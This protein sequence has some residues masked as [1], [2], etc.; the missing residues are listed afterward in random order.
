MTPT[1][2]EPLPAL[3]SLRFFAALWVM[4]FHMSDTDSHVAQLSAAPALWNLVSVGYRGVNLFFILS[5]FILVYNYVDTDF[6]DKQSRR[7]FW[8]ARFARIYPMY[9][10][11][12]LLAVPYVLRDMLLGSTSPLLLGTSLI[13]NLALLQSW[14]PPFALT[15]NGPGWSLSNE[16]WFYLIFPF[17]I[18]LLNPCSNRRFVGIILAATGYC[19][20][21]VGLAVVLDVPGFSGATELK[22]SDSNPLVNFFLFSPLRRVPEFVAG[23]ALGFLYLRS[24]RL[25]PNA[26]DGVTLVSGTCVLAVCCFG[27]EYLP[28]P[29]FH[30]GLL[31]PAWCGLIFGLAHSESRVAGLLSWQTLQ[32]LG[33]ASYAMYILHVRI[34]RYLRTASRGVGFELGDWSGEFIVMPLIVIVCSLF[35]WRYFEEPMR[36]I[37]LQRS[38]PQQPVRSS[39]SLADKAR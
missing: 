38:R 24:P 2:P 29:L 18:P 25:S 19:L 33:A 14:I 7:K 32:V 27:T 39:L 6:S 12:V 8:I 3:T 36:R 30:E 34:I 4:L 23:V 21:A 20:A 15:W 37:I 22:P 1:K 35:M 26:A 10:F 31:I 17:L 11:G 16:A 9:F 13:C 28:F 5:G